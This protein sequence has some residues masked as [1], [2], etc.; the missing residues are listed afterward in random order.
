MSHAAKHHWLRFNLRALFVVVVVFAGYWWMCTF[1]GRPSRPEVSGR[2]FIGS[3]NIA[4]A[5]LAFLWL[6]WTREQR[7]AKH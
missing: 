6:R 4:V 2:M 3:V 1:H 7:R 5:M